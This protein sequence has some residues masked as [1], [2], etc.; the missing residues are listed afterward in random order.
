MAME[1]GWNMYSRGWLKDRP[2]GP[3]MM[4]TQLPVSFLR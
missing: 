3:V 4:D 1:R 2:P